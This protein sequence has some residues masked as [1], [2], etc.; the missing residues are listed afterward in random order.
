MARSMTLGTL[1]L[2]G[3][4]LIGPARTA[5]ASSDDGGGNSPPSPFW[6]GEVYVGGSP[7]FTKEQPGVVAAP[8]V[9]DAGGFGLLD[10]LFSAG[11][12]ADDQRAAAEASAQARGEQRAGLVSISPTGR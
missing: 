12:R 4:L 11:R 5:F 2:M 8:A 10:W 7:D 1:A 3:L 6:V 9:A